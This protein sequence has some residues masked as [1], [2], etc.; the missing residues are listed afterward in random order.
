MATPDGKPINVTSGVPAVAVD[1]YG[2]GVNEEQGFAQIV[3]IQ[4]VNQK[5]P[6]EP[7]P[8]ELQ[9]TAVA[10]VRLSLDQLEK[11]NNDISNNL[12]KFKRNLS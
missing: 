6:G 1:G 5:K 8:K 7:E 3:F 12:K 10:S 4:V 11:L 2:I 9:G